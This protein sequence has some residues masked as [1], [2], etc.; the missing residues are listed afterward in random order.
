[1]VSLPTNSSF[2][3]HHLRGAVKHLLR[4]FPSPAR[5]GRGTG[6]VG[7]PGTFGPGKKFPPPAPSAMVKGPV[8][9]ASRRAGVRMA[10]PPDPPPR[11]PRPLLLVPVLAVVLL[12]LAVAGYAVTRYV[13]ADY[14]LGEARRDLARRDF[15]RARA[16]LALCLEVWGDSGEVHFLAAQA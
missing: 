6:R 16:H 3:L 15:P 12:A 8:T 9:P 1:R 14:H 2:Q 10:D 4:F 11:R 5:Q 7:R 13:W